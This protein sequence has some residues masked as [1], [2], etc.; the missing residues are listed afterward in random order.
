MRHILPFFRSLVA[1][2]LIEKYNFTQVEAAEKLGTTQAAISQYVHSKRGFRGMER[3]ED[4]LPLIQSA[5]SEIA[6]SIAVQKIN[7]EEVMSK[8]CELC[9]EIRGRI[10]SDQ[11]DK[12]E[13]PSK[14]RF[15]NTLRR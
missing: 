7:A 2:N 14:P 6:R 9:T 15:F 12:N 5:S 3:F 4:I 10:I 1:K 8:F 11:S 13:V